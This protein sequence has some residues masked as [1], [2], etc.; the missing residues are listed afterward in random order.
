MATIT[1][2]AASDPDFSIL[3]RLLGDAG[4]AATLDETSDLTVF[5]PTN[6]AFAALAASLGFAGDGG[7]EEAVLGFLTAALTELGGG[8]PIGPL[9]DVLTY[10]VASGALSAAELRAA[11]AVTTLQGAAVTSDGGDTLADLDPSAE[12]PT[13][14]ATDVAADNGV[15]HVIDRVLLP[16]DLVGNNP[17][18]AG[19][20]AGSSDF[21]ILVELL[22]AADLLDAVSAPDA[23]LTVFAP[24][25]AASARSRSISASTARR[26][27]RR[28]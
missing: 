20:A 6:A 3:T 16:L 12:D 22:G 23:D 21:S 24:T 5:A 8:D 13:L 11:G 18:I 14:V 1:E 19:I 9:T 25:N 4:L 28:R 2:I 17:T 27:T 26:T 7:D 15:V 10:H